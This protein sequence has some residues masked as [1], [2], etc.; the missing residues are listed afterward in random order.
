MAAFLLLP[1]ESGINLADVESWVER[2]RTLGASAIS[3][4]RVGASPLAAGHDG[5]VTL[6][7]PVAASRRILPETAGPYQ[8]EAEDRTDHDRVPET[9]ADGESVFDGTGQTAVE[10]S[11]ARREAR[12]LRRL[13]LPVFS[14]PS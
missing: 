7:V 5:G 13:P 12:A 2:A 8:A 14:H 4:V 9:E 3:P 10:E 1:T 11:P 6:S